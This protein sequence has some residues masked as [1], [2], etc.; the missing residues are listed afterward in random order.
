MSTNLHHNS[1]WRFH[2]GPSFRSLSPKKPSPV[3]SSI[4]AASGASGQEEHVLEVLPEA[5]RHGKDSKRSSASHTSSF[6]PLEGIRA[7][8]DEI[9]ERRSFHVTVIIGIAIEVLIGLTEISLAL[10]YD[11]QCPRVEV[12]QS[13]SIAREVL[14]FVGYVIVC[15]FL[16]E[17]FVKLFAYRF[18]YFTHAG[19]IID[20]VVISISFSLDT[21]ALSN[22]DIESQQQDFASIL[23]ILRLWRVFRI[24]HGVT[25]ELEI[26]HR[27]QVSKLLQEIQDLQMEL[28]QSKPHFE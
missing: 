1:T 24:V 19:N 16:V 4:A 9:M 15:I 14:P 23:L 3:I 11:T 12:P 7:Q 25:D 6:I 20:L 10:Y 22:N 5:R 17:T 28:A 18:H 13:I 21:F 27:Q 2:F 8:I 26:H